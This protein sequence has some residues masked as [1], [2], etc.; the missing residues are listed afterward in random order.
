MRWWYPLV[1]VRSIFVTFF[2]LPVF[3]VV[4]SVVVI[5]LVKLRL[6][7]ENHVIKWWAQS[8]CWLYGVQVVVRRWF[9]STQAPI[10]VKDYQNQSLEDL[11]S[12]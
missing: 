3:T 5:A 9:S 4:G 1:L 11:V 12:R 7:G 6:G 8:L 2:Y 10:L